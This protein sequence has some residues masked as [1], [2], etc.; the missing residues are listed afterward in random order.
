MF[1]LLYEYVRL[2]F[3]RAS[4][5]DGHKAMKEVHV[6]PCRDVGWVAFVMALKTV[7]T[8]EFL[9]LISRQYGMLQNGKQNEHCNH[10][11]RNTPYL[12]HP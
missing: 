10:T 3:F 8:A 4:V 2:V 1:Q 12:H 5:N 6:D 11:C 9:E 7:E